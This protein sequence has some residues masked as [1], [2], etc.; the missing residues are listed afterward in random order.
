MKKSL[1]KGYF[2]LELNH[3]Y[4]TDTVGAEEAELE[5]N[6]GIV[7]FKAKLK[8]ASDDQAS[9]ADQCKESSF[10]NVEYFSFLD[11]HIRKGMSQFAKAYKQQIKG[12]RIEVNYGQKYSFACEVQPMNPDGV[13]FHVIGT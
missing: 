8:P 9:D 5:L 4:G 1:R 3:Q 12:W 11:E 13:M 7:I 6:D 10:S 2:H